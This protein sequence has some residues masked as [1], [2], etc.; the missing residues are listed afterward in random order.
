[1]GSKLMEAMEEASRVK[2]AHIQLEKDN[3]GLKLSV[4][5][6]QQ[7]HD[8][9]AKRHEATLKEVKEAR[10][11]S[12]NSQEQIAMAGTSMLPFS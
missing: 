11:R 5:S 9:L 1:M 10:K 4:K 8:D 3:T 6:L 12:S 7:K 2:K